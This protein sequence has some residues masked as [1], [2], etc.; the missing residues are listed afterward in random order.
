MNTQNI[1]LKNELKKTMYEI[2]HYSERSSDTESHLFETYE[3]REAYIKAKGFEY[4]N[5]SF[6]K[7]FSLSEVQVTKPIKGNGEK[8]T[9]RVTTYFDPY[10]DGKSQPEVHRRYYY[11]SYLSKS[12]IM[13]YFD[14]RNAVSNYYRQVDIKFMPAPLNR[15]IMEFEKEYYIK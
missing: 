10:G 2:T 15:R 4:S 3:E 11:Y 12:E 13:Y 14:K 1:N 8:T 7:W 9:F 6:D 5:R